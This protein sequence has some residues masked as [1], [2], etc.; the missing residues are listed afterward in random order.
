MRIPGGQ[1]SERFNSL[2]NLQPVKRP[3]AVESAMLGE[4]RAR[5][6]S[7]GGRRRHAGRQEARHSAR[8][9]FSVRQKLEHLRFT[10]IWGGVLP[11]RGCAVQRRSD[12]QAPPPRPLKSNSNNPQASAIVI[13]N[14]ALRN[15]IP[16][17]LLSLPRRSWAWWC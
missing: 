13:V 5:S 2:S 14:R 4:E 17:S 10:T 9:S 6:C 12:R 3:S 11:R 16:A 1:E 8:R 15:A 7:L